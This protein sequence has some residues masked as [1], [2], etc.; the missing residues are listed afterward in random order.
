M[1]CRPLFTDAAD[2]DAAATIL[3]AAF[4]GI[5]PAWCDLAAAQASLACY[6]SEPYIAYG[7]FVGDTLV[8]WIGAMPQYD[9]NTWE[10]HPLAVQPAHQCQGVGRALVAH[11]CAALAAAGTST[12]IVWCD[13]EAGT[14]SLF[15]QSLFPDPLGALK[16]LQSSPR[17]AG[18]FYLRCGFALSGVIPD[19]NGR[20]M[21]DFLYT[22]RL[23]D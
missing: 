4:A 7:A 1:I 18:G 2:S 15:G 8:G 17:H 6:R 12:L 9:G 20:G 11:F 16:T 23:T 10:L 5:S 14:T 13:D 19:A 21:H 3:V 22:R